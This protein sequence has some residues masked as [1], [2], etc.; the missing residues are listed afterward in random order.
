MQWSFVKF[1]IVW[2]CLPCS[3]TQSLWTSGN[4]GRH[5]CTICMSSSTEFELLLPSSV[6]A[7]FKV[8][9]V[10]KTEAA[11]LARRAWAL[12]LQ[13]A[14]ANLENHCLCNFSKVTFFGFL[15]TCTPPSLLR[16]VQSW[17]LLLCPPMIRCLGSFALIMV[18]VMLI[19]Y[20]GYGDVDVDFV[21]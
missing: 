2:V 6:T 21:S 4:I 14:W 3:I 16:L 9:E 20:H 18:M 12:V 13:V 8:C 19:L 5:S 1:Q 7:A 17:L 10:L 15:Q 11:I